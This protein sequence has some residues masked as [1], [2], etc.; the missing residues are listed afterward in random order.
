MKE[1]I[2]DIFC[3]KEQKITP[4]KGVVDHNGEFVFYCTSEGCDRFKKFPAGTT[5]EKFTEMIK[6]HE[7]QN[8]GQISIEEQNKKLEALIE[9]EIIG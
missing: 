6:K 2:K 1:V 3:A 9:G 8:Q 5:P 4:H 7:E